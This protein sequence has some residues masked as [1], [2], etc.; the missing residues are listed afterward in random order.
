VFEQE[1]NHEAILVHYICD[2]YFIG[3]FARNFQS[4]SQNEGIVA[5]FMVWHI[6]IVNHAYLTIWIR[7]EREVLVVVLFVLVGVEV[8]AVKIEETM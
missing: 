4:F 8:D 6:D 2:V 3:L 1:S 5:S 7:F